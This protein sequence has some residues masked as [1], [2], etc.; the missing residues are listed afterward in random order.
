[1]F[2]E[3]G[4]VENIIKAMVGEETASLKNIISFDPLKEE[5]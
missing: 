4:T 2:V 5:T 1:M 3:Q